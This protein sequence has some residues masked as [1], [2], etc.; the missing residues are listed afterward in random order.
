MKFLISRISSQPDHL[1]A[2]IL[3]GEFSQF[4]PK[5]IDSDWLLP[6]VK[7]S[8]KSVT[9]CTSWAIKVHTCF[10][11]HRSESNRFPGIR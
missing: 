7:A 1:L 10:S 2:W 4:Q 5:A 9:P 8:I 6:L 11:L 3:L